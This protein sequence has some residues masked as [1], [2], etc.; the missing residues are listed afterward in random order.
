MEGYN[1]D[2][3][4][5]FLHANFVFGFDIQGLSLWRLTLNLLVRQTSFSSLRSV[6]CPQEH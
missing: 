3:S 5:A 6:S 2:K 4:L 1:T